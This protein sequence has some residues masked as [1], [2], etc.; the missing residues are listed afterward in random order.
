MR[1]ILNKIKQ[2]IRYSS[3]DNGSVVIEASISL[4]AFMFLVM[5]L[6]TLVNAC[7]VQARVGVAL[8]E[9][10]KEFSEF[11]YV[12]SLF[13][14]NDKQKEFY[15]SLSGYRMD[16]DDAIGAMG[17]TKEAL[18]TIA[19]IDP[20]S[21][22]AWDDWNSSLDTLEESGQ[23]YEKIYENIKADPGEYFL[24]MGKVAL[25]EGFEFF[26]G[27]VAG[28]FIAKGLMYKHLREDSKQDPNLFLRRHGVKDGLSGLKLYNSTVFTNG[29]DDIAFICQYKIRMVR[30]LNIDVEYEV[31]QLA[32]TKAWTGNA[33]VRDKDNDPTNNDSSDAGST[34]DSG[35]DS[36][37][38]G[39][40]SSSDDGSSSSDSSSTGS[41]EEGE[42]DPSEGS[43]E[44]EGPSDSSD[45][46]STEE[47]PEDEED[48]AY[49][50]MRK[51]M[52][53]KYGEDVVAKIEAEYGDEIKDWDEEVWSIAAI[54]YAHE[55]NCP[56]ILDKNEREEYDKN[57]GNKDNSGE[58][59]TLT[60][61][62][63]SDILRNRPEFTG[64]NRQKL[65]SMVSDPKLYKIINELYRPTASTGDG[66]TADKLRE[67]YESG[68]TKANAK[69][70]QKAAARL[71]E[72][73]K[74]IKSGTL[75]L[76]DLDVAE[77]LRDDLEEALA[78]FEK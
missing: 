64:T 15:E 59:S 53:A 8:H 40:S 36:S 14:F 66:G 18:D 73:D 58:S 35:E 48:A 29:T 76:N 57:Y 74:L 6:L 23:K 4:T 16:I 49:K 19:G 45:E 65:L 69:H 60:T 47:T 56:E 22:S 38:S 30:L 39:D 42:D 7:I 31:C 68:C 3:N 77:A 9:S 78:L 5:T 27:T 75:D 33:L 21:D 20:L 43:T 50:A 37:D 24:G 51:K 55:H 41:S 71:K 1:Q 34:E 62:H 46:G 67:E 10:A 61:N 12:Y 32:K 2:K 25:N 11:G 70:Y 26:K 44:E 17:D 28:Q 63:V 72:L 54:I 13:G 52:V